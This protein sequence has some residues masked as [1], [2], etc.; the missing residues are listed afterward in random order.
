MKV[1]KLLTQ[2]DDPF[3]LKKARIKSFKEATDEDI[4]TLK[5]LSN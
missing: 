2:L 5:K 4:T 3:I 1:K